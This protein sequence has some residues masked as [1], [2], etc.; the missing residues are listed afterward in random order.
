MME[1]PALGAESW[2]SATSD[3]RLVSEVCD[4]VTWQEVVCQYYSQSGEVMWSCRIFARQCLT[5]IKDE[6]VA[7][8]IVPIVATMDQE[9]C[10]CEDGTSVPAVA[11]KCKLIY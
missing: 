11:H 9:L 6:G 1:C 10:V 8:S 7:E 2:G 4:S 5:D 3:Q